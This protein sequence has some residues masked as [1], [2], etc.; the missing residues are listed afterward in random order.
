MTKSAAGVRSIAP[1]YAIVAFATACASLFFVGGC[2]RR[3][4]PT[5]ADGASR[6]HITGIIAD[7]AERPLAGA[8]VRVLD[9]PMGGTT[10]ATTNVSGRFELFGTAPGMVTLEINREGFKSTRYTTQWQAANSG[11]IEIIRLESLEVSPFE[12]DP[13]EY[14]VTISIDPADARD[15]G[16]LPQCAGFPA[17]MMS[18]SFKATIAESSHHSFDRAVTLNGPTVFSNSEFGLLLGSQ[19]IG[20]ELESP[21]TEEF[22]GY[23]YLNVMGVAPTSEP[24][25]VSGGAVSVPFSAVFQYCELN[26]P[27]RRGWENCQHAATVRFH[28][29]GSNRARMTFTKSRV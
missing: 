14:T 12:L 6:L 4:S 28:A 26:A 3:S 10:V 16:P 7:R 24:A 20:F 13:G 1:S 22:P 23:K 18:R 21:F 2:E 27:A 25:S 9:G 19:F 8:T 11:G 17:E 5:A 29:C 15:F